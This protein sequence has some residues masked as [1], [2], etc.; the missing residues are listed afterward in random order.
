MCQDALGSPVDLSTPQAMAVTMCKNPSDPSAAPDSTCDSEILK[1]DARMTYQPCKN[2]HSQMDPYSRVLQNFGP[3]GNYRT[4]DEAG[5]SIDPSATGVQAFAKAVVSSGVLDGCSV[6]QMTDYVMGLTIQKYNTCE[7]N[8]IRA[9][10]DGTIKSLF[11]NVL[12]ASFMRAR[13]GGTK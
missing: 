8:T 1:S 9:Q 6:Q 3:I 10:T 5:R 2:C 11:S 12:L 13:T 7:L 4:L